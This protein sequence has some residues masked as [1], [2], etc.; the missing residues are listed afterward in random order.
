MARLITADQR[1]DE[2]YT[3]RLGCATASKFDI[4]MAGQKYAG[5]KNYRA[6]LVLERITGEP[7]EMFQSKAMEWG[8]EFEEVAKNEYML[9]T[10]NVITDTGF[11]LHDSLKAGASPDGLIGES[12]GWE[13]K[14]PN[15]ATHIETLHAGKIPKKY[16]AQV[17]GQ[18][19]I[20]GLDWVDF[21]S[22]DPRLPE[23]AQ[24]FIQRVFR[25]DDYIGR[26]EESVTQ[27]LTEVDAEVEFIKAY[28]APAIDLEKPKN[29]T[30]KRKVAA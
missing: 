28:K 20:V 17:Q 25:D 3:A 9:A 14:A 27:F 23:Q 30:I 13:N 7:V 4:I 11:Y 8:T 24:L 15:T 18:M 29:I 26:L 10:G 2:W 1:T 19:W 6:E 12:G 21:T 16:V 22:Y 5:W